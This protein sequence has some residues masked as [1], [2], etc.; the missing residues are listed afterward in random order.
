MAGI[1]LDPY[2]KCKQNIL[3]PSQ[4]S[5]LQQECFLFIKNG[6]IT[7]GHCYVQGP[8]FPSPNIQGKDK[9]A[10]LTH[11]DTSPPQQTHPQICF[12]SIKLKQAEK[13]FSSNVCFLFI[14]C[15]YLC[16]C[17]KVNVLEPQALLILHLLPFKPQ[18]MA[19]EQLPLCSWQEQDCSR[20]GA[21]RQNVGNIN[22]GSQWDRN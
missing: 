10:V 17:S 14:F 6:V 5:G 16:A 20:V 3:S 18:R 7:K 11:M 19:L 2:V 13:Y 8:P 9:E 21:N 12:P 22:K 15:C 1:G 4:Y